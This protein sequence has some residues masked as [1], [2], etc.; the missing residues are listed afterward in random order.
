ML[1]EIL[2]RYMVG[3][4]ALLREV[5]AYIY[6]YILMIAYINGQLRGNKREKPCMPDRL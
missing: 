2:E 1:N 4:Y 6:I 5:S 3:T